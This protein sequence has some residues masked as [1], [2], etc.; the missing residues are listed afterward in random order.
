MPEGELKHVSQSPLWD[1]ETSSFSD[2]LDSRRCDGASV[3]FRFIRAGFTHTMVWVSA[4]PSTDIDNRGSCFGLPGLGVVLAPSGEVG[5]GIQVAVESLS[6]PTREHSLGECQIVVVGAASRTDPARC[7][8]A[9]SEQDSTAEPCLLIPDHSRELS[10]S[11]IADRARQRT[12]AQHSRNVQVFQNEP[13]VGFDQLVGHLMQEMKA[14]ISNAMMM[15]RQPARSTLSLVGSLLFSRQCS[16]QTPL[17]THSRRQ[18]ARHIDH[19]RDFVTVTCGGDQERRQTT[20]NSNPTIVIGAVTVAALR[21]QV[22]GFD[23]NRHPPA[24]RMVGDRG[25]QDLRPPAGQHPA[26]SSGVVV[27][28]HHTDLGEGYR[29]WDCVVTDSDRRAPTTSLIIAD[30]ERSGRAGLRL[31]PWKPHPLTPTSARSRLRPCRQSVPAIDGRFFEYLLAH[32][33][34]PRQP[35]RGHDRITS[36]VDCDQS[37]GGFGLLPPVEIVD[38]IESRPR[39]LRIRIVT[40][41]GQRGLHHGQ[42][43]VEREPRRSGVSVQQRLLLDRGVQ[44]EPKRSVPHHIR[45]HPSSHRQLTADHR[46]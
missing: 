16:R 12:V 40:A 29:P 13:V 22:S 28:S 36:G 39:H 8:P 25:V 5:R 24:S 31:E 34:P 17:P 33:V 38:Q 35:G 30:S 2:V 43:L 42:T 21:V 26:Q 15:T 9:V 46:V 44:A 19:A 14:N 27:Y 37:S 32:Q 4:V 10:P 3:G 41:V 6:A 7:K 11:R 20:I 1:W 45:E 18:R 23:V